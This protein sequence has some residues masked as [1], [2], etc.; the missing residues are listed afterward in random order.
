MSF[1]PL[2]ADADSGQTSS[3][4]NERLTVT[5]TQ[6]DLAALIALPQTELAVAANDFVAEV[7]PDFVYNHSVRSYVFARAIAKATGMTDYDDELVFLSCVLHDVGATEF[8][9]GDQ[10]FEVDGADAAAAFLRA[11]DVD[12]SRVTTVWNAIALHTSLGLA[13]RFGPVEAVA[14]IGIGADIV[15]FGKE[16]LPAGLA[17]LAHATW[18]RHDLGYAL[19]EA[20]ARQV[21]ANPG[22]GGPL[23]F[24]GQ[25]HQLLY[26]TN[27][28]STWF[29]VLD[30]AGWGDRPANAR[31]DRRA[32]Q[33]PE[34]LSDL[35][36]RYLGA[37]D[38]DGLVSLYE[39][40]ALFG[41]APGAPVAGTDAIRMALGGL[42]ESGSQITLTPRR[43]QILDDVAVLSHT[44]SVRSRGSDTEAVEVVTTEVA[45]RQHDGRWLYLFDDPF[46]GI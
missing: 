36:M 4:D 44:A 3:T 7:A 29:D 42:I 38:V 45:R 19:S 32:A 10:R 12:E 37:G 18:P 9:N 13:H 33:R 34:E 15:G 8:A 22:K 20:I 27:P 16:V 6:S 11:R 39:P 40:R 1:W 43:V 26:G 5:T 25:V 17:D 41:S 35:F 30:A 28:A 23:T 24:P 31:S 14:Q 21:A 46:F 2:S